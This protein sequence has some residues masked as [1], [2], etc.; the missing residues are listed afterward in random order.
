MVEIKT[1]TYIDFQSG[2]DGHQKYYKNGKLVSVVWAE[3]AEEVLSW[4][5]KDPEDNIGFAGVIKTEIDK[6]DTEK[7]FHKAGWFF[8]KEGGG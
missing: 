4:T 5:D 2:I 7:D 8:D 6:Y 1:E 3:S